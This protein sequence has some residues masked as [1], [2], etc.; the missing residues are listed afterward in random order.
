MSRQG[1]QSTETNKIDLKNTFYFLNDEHVIHL[2][3][4]LN[5]EY[6]M[7]EKKNL[8]P[9]IESSLQALIDILSRTDK[10]R[11]TC[12]TNPEVFVM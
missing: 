1:A 4:A 9:L 7:E 10:S 12:Y 6:F 2:T 3:A 5:Y 8:N 11:Y